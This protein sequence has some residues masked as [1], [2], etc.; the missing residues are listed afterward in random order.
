MGLTPYAIVTRCT[1]MYTFNKMAVL[2]I[3]RTPFAIVGFRVFI[4]VSYF[5][6]KEWMMKDMM[7]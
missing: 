1:L 5:L 6:M 7:K 2:I 3:A 4:A